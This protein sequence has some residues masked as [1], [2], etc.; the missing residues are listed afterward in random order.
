MAPQGG[1]SITLLL[2]LPAQISAE[3]ILKQTIAVIW[4]LTSVADPD[5][6]GVCR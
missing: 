1:D 2:G 4:G 3:Y 6:P 5:P